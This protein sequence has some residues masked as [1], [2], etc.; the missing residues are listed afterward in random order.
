VPSDAWLV[1]RN[2]APLSERRV[3][4]RIRRG[5]WIAL[6][7]VSPA[8][9]SAL[10]AAEDKRFMEHR[11]VDWTGLAGAAWD[12]VW[13]TLDGRRVRGGSTL[14]MQ[15]AGLL[16][17]ALA[18]GGATRTLGQKWDQARAALAIERTWSKREIL[19][20]YLNLVSYRGELAGLDAA[21]RGLFGKAPTGLDAREAAI[22]VAL[23]R[24]TRASPGIVGQRACAVAAQVAADSSCSDIRTLAEATLTGAYRLPPR[25]DLAP[26]LAARLLKTPGERVATTLDADL[27]R[28]ASEVLRR[29]IAELADLDV[30]DGALVVLDNASGEVLA[31][32]GS[33][34]ELSRAARV[35]GV[36]APRQAGSTLK[37]FLYALALDMRVA[38]AASLVD[39]SPLAL[40][41]ARGLYVPQNYDRD[42]HGPVSV[43]TALASSL[44][45]PAVRTLGLVGLDRF[46]ETLARL[47]FATMTEPAD[48][49]G[50]ALALGGVDVTLLALANAYRA[51]A[52]GGIAGP[53]RM[54][55][56][57]THD[58]AGERVFG[59]DASFVV[60]DIL[61]DRGARALTF[62]LES[63][64]ATSAPA[65]VKT[66]T[67]KDLRDNWCVGFTARYTIGV[68]VGNFSG[69]P[70]RDVSGVT[71]AA[72]VFRDVVAYLHAAGA[73]Q[74]LAAPSG[75][76][77]ENVR[78]EP[79]VEPERIEWFVRGTE[80]TVVRA[81][82]TGTATTPQIRYPAPDTVIALDPDLPPGH[83]RVVFEAAPVIGGLQWRVDDTVLADERGRAAWTPRRGRHTLSLTDAAG[84][85]LSQV[86]FEVR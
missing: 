61:A 47:G 60:A 2:G 25:I 18:A 69:A 51:L 6:A 68:W 23:L 42:F 63:P 36:T 66:G 39:D 21:A 9:S 81:I 27:Q 83:E 50:A 55:L 54:L 52:N 31:Y 53:T 62:G 28:H 16:D 35:D 80:M 85:T 40:P 64:L 26:H 20:A 70:M 78:F 75:V 86:A 73:P 46:H 38:T 71:G 48:H 79:P 7:D 4:P 76:V 84:R 34:G 82:A 32:V 57:T 59:R 67:S 65:A 3:D 13:R 43:R 10:I 12:S 77:R 14:T 30:E 19:E 33:S 44:N 17:P 49:Y 56:G 15:L 1:D 45:V 41:T 8:L 37:P 24:G 5:D 58:V 29:R 74:P 72:P 11:G 22:L